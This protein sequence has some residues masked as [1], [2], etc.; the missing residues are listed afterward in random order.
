MDSDH[1]LN[2]NFNRCRI[3]PALCDVAAVAKYSAGHLGGIVPVNLGAGH[4]F[5]PS[6]S[7]EMQG[8]TMSPLSLTGSEKRRDADEGVGRSPLSV[9]DI[10]SSSVASS[11]GTPI[12]GSGFSHPRWL[13]HNMTSSIAMPTARS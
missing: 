9:I 5:Y 2:S 3:L 11:G 12:E 1:D 10:M 8:P 6:L 7:P 4:V 13:L